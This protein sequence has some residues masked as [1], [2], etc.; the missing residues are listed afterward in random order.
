MMLVGSS[1]P[2]G[3]IALA[4]F[5]LL[6]VLI[7]SWAIKTRNRLVQLDEFCGNAMS[8]IGVQQSSRW[9]ALTALA[10]Q[11]KQFA[12]HEYKT[13][14]DI[15]GRRQGVTQS[16]SA[17]VADGQNELLGQLT[18]RLL[19]VSEA[20]PELKSAALYQ[21]TMQGIKK[22][23]DNVRFSR[24]AYNDTIT[25]LNREVR[26]FPACLIAGGMGFFVKEY[27]AAENGKTQM[28]EL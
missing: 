22:Y 10:S 8:Q 23:E 13:M 18:S 20:Y 5:L 26:A 27:L 1:L 28:P 7:L 3:W 11:T 19:A 17:Q 2:L 16:T 9:D 12:A 24:M 14:V 21:E 25:K 4:G 15:I 6:I